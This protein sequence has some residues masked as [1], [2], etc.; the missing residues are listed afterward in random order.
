MFYAELKA[1]IL[2]VTSLLLQ[3]KLEEAVFV[4][5]CCHLVDVSPWFWH[6]SIPR[7]LEGRF[8][9]LINFNYS[10]SR[11]YAAI[12]SSEQRQSYKNDFN[13]EYNEYRDLH[14]RI[15]RITRR[16]TQL[17]AK[18]KQLLQGSEEYK[19]ET[20]IIRAFFFSL[21]FFFQASSASGNA[22]APWFSRSVRGAGGDGSVAERPEPRRGGCRTCT[23]LTALWTVLKTA[24]CSFVFKLEHTSWYLLT[25]KGLSETI[26]VFSQKLLE[27]ISVSQ[28]ANSYS[29]IWERI[30][31][32]RGVSPGSSVP[33]ESLILI[34]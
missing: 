25:R 13:A 22:T 10:P 27:A 4:P 32:G 8:T 14:A 15:E 33:L 3:C 1:I 5:K 9:K 30:R 34:M 19:V 16:F 23:Q 31:A 6:C 18:L 11:K 12:S 17:D 21:L 7:C 28:P 29:H 20:E 26:G 2:T 24:L